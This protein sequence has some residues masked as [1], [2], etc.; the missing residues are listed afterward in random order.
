[1]YEI[2]YV[3]FLC[4]WP[5][6]YFDEHKLIFVELRVVWKAGDP[7]KKCLKKS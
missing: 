5:E 3:L 4:P 6:A 7:M 2:N 1:V